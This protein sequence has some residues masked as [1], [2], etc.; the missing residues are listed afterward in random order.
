MRVDRTRPPRPDA[1]QQLEACRRE[2]AEARAEALAQQA[3]SSQV[4]QVISSSPGEL[5]PVFQAL[6]E[7]AVRICDANFG[8]MYLRDGEVFRLAAAHNT[9]PALA[10]QRKRTP[11]R[12]SSNFG[13]MLETKQAV[14]VLDLAV[15]QSYLDRDSDAVPA[16][17]LGHIRTALFVPMLKDN[18]PIGGVVIYRQEV[19]PFADRHIELVRNF[20]A[21]AVIAIENTRL[22]NEL[23]ESLQQQT[24]TADVL[25][26]ISSSPG[27]LEPVFTAMLENALRI[28]EAKFG[29]LIR[30]VDGAFVT[31]VMVGAPPPLVDAL[32]HKPFKPAPGIPLERV[33]RTKKLVHTLDAAEEQHKPLSA[34]LAGAR[35]HIVVPMLKDDELI[36]VISI[37]R[38]E[39]RPFSDKQIELLAS[40]ANQA[41]I[42]IENARLLNELRESLQQQT[43]TAD[44]LKV[45][46]RSTFDLQAV[47]DTLVESAVRLCEADMGHIA[48]PN[49]QRFFRSQASFGF[50]PKVKEELERTPFRPGRG[51]VIGRALLERA[52]VQVL[53]AQTDP[54]YELSKAQKFGRYRTV[55]G[56]P[57]LR[58]GTPIGVFGLGRTSVRPFTHKQVELLTTF[59]DQAVIA[60]ENVRL[61]DEVQART[62]E[63]AEALEQQTATSEVLHVISSSP[64]ELEPVFQAMLENAVR[65]CDAK[66]GTLHR[67]DGKVFRLAAG[68]GTPSEL[69]EFQKRRGPFRPEPGGPLDR[70]LNTKQVYCSSDE[71]AEVS[72]GVSARLGGARS[73][74]A[75]PMLQEDELVGAILIYRQEV[76]PFTPKQIELVAN[77][78]NQAVIAIENTRLLNELRES[79]QQQTATAEVLQVISGSP[80]ELQPVFGAMLRSA[81][82]ICV[83][84]FAN[85]LLYDGS[86]FRV[87]ATHGAPPG[88][89]ELRRRE[90]TFHPRPNNPLARLV[91]TK[92]LQHIADIRVEDAYV[93]GDPSFV[94]LGEV[95]GART[96]L[97]VPMLKE[98]ELVGAIGIYRQEVRPFA[99]KQIELVTNFAAQA[100]IA[101]E[102]TR[103][104]N[105]L[106]ESL[107][108]Q[109]ATADV[110]KIIS[111]SAFD[112]Q[113]VL[114]T[115]VES[116]AR[117]C[118]ADMAT[119]SQAKGET[120]LQ[121]AEYGYSA[122]HKKYMEQ[123]PVPFGRGSL[124]GRVLM[125]GSPLQILDALADPEYTF[126]APRVVGVRT[127]LG[128]PLLREG[129]PIGVIVL[130]RKTVRPF[131][132]RQVE[133]VSTFADQA[134]IA[135]EN[136]RLFDEIQDKSRQLAEASQHKSQFLASMSHELRTPLNAIIGLTEMMVTNTARFGTEKAQEP[137]NRVHRA[138]A[139]LL[140][141]INQVLDLSKI[142]AGKLELSPQTVELAPLIDEVI[143]TARHLAD[144]NK[145]RLV[146]EAQE[147]LGAL[148]VD[149]MRLRQILLNLLSNACKFTKQ[150]EIALKARKAANGS[151]FIE[152]AV[153]DTGIGMTAEQQ[154]KLFEEF[155]QAEATTAQRFGG[156]GLGLAIARKL[157]RMM[158][159][160][161]TVASEPGKG[162]VFTV[163]LP[164][165]PES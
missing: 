15:E 45:I 130:Q 10:E 87:A 47:L 67:F 90:P 78:A 61:F 97:I 50:S 77:F 138:G 147:N 29:M 13:R 164:G 108:Q 121:V 5:E 131:T 102:N 156:T 112:L 92:Q 165:G 42:A 162:S 7:N 56:A 99:D 151:D 41:V 109:T 126:E 43:A 6:L 148:T 115:L 158:G 52:V 119:I 19:R 159:G 95:A 63:L 107:K 110:L 140:G 142:E 24:A 81:T 40:F 153:A 53:D 22:L 85:L 128:A 20:A 55:I 86:A 66:F 104:L 31:Q 64:G 11:L 155:S 25:R 2:L 114:D 113:A 60:I 134:V 1:E 12:G 68:F 144:Q 122:E 70:V 76:K 120:H 37:Y 133:L 48:R 28:C 98:D 26:V 125:E 161:I 91:R 123:H 93:E 101:I 36:G 18:E 124:V 34:E 157:A 139:H 146:V 154:A 94:P 141:L 35:T 71:A 129:A 145:N 58:E 105:E 33:L 73:L 89:A 49:G 44:V 79:L 88:W 16:V 111:R 137:L 127:M 27:G 32:L 30:Y 149:P 82:Y 118:E 38:Q 46:S 132:E 57:L 3:A 54:E 75:V 163:R 14:H 4:L 80:G 103:L 143:G 116:A 100:V 83:A 72:P 152:L 21:Q 136:V 74:V 150:G 9:P 106:R 59:A 135:I 17:E 69:S 96:L 39:V 23:R 8:N 51:S 65:I 160:D 62:R 84:E 117:L